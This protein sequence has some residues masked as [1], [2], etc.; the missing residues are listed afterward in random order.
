MSRT[1]FRV[2]LQTIDCLNSRNALL[3]V[4]VIPELSVRLR[5]KKLWVRISLLSLQKYKL[6]VFQRIRK[7]LNTRKVKVLAIAL[8]NTQFYYASMIWMFAEKRWYQKFKRYITEHCILYT[9]NHMKICYL[10]MMIS[11][12]IKIIYIS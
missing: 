3:E 12:F 1:S 6:R 4:G 5:T 9:R 11:L 2:N 10:W 8:S 7:Y